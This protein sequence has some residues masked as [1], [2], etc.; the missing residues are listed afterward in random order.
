[1]FELV[2]ALFIGTL[3]KAA[4]AVGWILART[5][6]LLFLYPKLLLAVLLAGGA[7]WI[8]FGH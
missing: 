4:E 8:A 1:M 2:D 6:G 7:W 5:I 3:M